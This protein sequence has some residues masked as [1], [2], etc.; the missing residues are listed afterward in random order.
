MSG[1]VSPDIT[2][3]PAT[4]R[5]THRERKQKTKCSKKKRGRENRKSKEIMQIILIQEWHINV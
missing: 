4:K 1:D 3:P 2:P 5:T